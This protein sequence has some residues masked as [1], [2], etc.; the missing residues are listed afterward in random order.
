MNYFC[1][2]FCWFSS[3]TRLTPWINSEIK[4]IFILFTFKAGCHHLYWHPLHEYAYVS[5]GSVVFVQLTRVPNTQTHRPDTRDIATG[6][7]YALRTGDALKKS[8]TNWSGRCCVMRH[9]HIR[10]RL[11]LPDQIICHWVIG[12]AVVSDPAQSIH[13]C[14]AVTYS[15][16][17]TVSDD[18][19]Y[20]HLP[21]P[22]LPMPNA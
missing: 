19:G 11:H 4:R 20:I 5:I 15:R 7:I 8:R 21:F 2:I 6:R 22:L 3:Q 18:V 9:Y 10:L 14:F 12:Y 13:I 16:M 17:V 1:G